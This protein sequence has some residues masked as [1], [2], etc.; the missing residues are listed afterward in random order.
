MTQHL[1]N[2]F[3]CDLEPEGYESLEDGGTVPTA[4]RHIGTIEG[5][6]IGV[7]EAEPGLIGGHTDDEVFV[8]LEG[9]AEVTFED[10][11]ETIHIGPGD[12]VR[13][14]PGQRNR[15]RTLERIRKVSIW[16][17]RGPRTAEA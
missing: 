13:L 3:T 8:V 9:R 6:H 15:W 4:T 10:T 7:W 11:K 17:D 2:A 12:I 1:G 16:S 5:V 14:N